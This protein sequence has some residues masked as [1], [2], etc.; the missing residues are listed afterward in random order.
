MGQDQQARTDLIR[1]AADVLRRGGLVALPTETVYGLGA[2]ATNAAA[3]RRIFAAKGRPATNPLIVH[4]A[5][6][7]MAASCV[8]DWPEAAERLAARFW[9]GPLTLVLPRASFIADEVTAG[10][11]T[12]GVRVPNH[13][14]A[15]ELLRTFGGGVAAP[16]ANRSNHVSPTT[17][18]HVRDDLG[19]TVDFILDGGPCQVGIESTVLSLAGDVPT[20]LRLGGINLD[21][22]RRVIGEVAV[23][24]G[25]DAG[26]AASPGRQATHYAPRVPAIARDTRWFRRVLRDFMEW[27][28]APQSQPAVV[29][30][31]GGAGDWF[32]E[33]GYARYR[34]M[35]R[36]AAAYAADLY[37]ALRW[38]ESCGAREIYVELPPDAPEWA[39]VRD[40]LRRATPDQPRHDVP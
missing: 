26:V 32:R 23:R 1:E 4:A 9:P 3:V 10:G 30:L 7:W 25:S 35:P 6:R 21:E 18:A 8:A 33:V 15:L 34:H 28:A 31:E 39:A 12:V 11:P 27:H 29:G 40:R 13:P 14:V 38:A 2:D 17:A 5:D 24:G 37:A 19:E 36:D 20:V 22:L 16:S